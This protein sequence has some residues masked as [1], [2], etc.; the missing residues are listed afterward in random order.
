MAQVCSGLLAV[1]PEK[2]SV[3]LKYRFSGKNCEVVMGQYEIF[4]R[5]TFLT[6]NLPKSRVALLHLGNTKWLQQFDF[7]GRN[8]L[9]ERKKVL[10]SF[11]KPLVHP[12]VLPSAEKKPKPSSMGSGL[13]HYYDGRLDR[14]SFR[15]KG[16]G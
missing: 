8:K 3:R 7:A 9:D 12:C 11:K 10:N 1:V 15:A 5:V 6:L 16:M 13:Q 4:P 2:D 14:T